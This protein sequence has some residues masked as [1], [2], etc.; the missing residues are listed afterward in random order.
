MKAILVLLFLIPFSG[1]SQNTLSVVVQKVNS[2][3]GRVSVAV[4]NESEGFLDF[5]KVYRSGSTRANMGTTTVT[6]DDLP[7]GIYAV[8]VFHDINDNDELDTNWM[9]IPKEDVGFS[10]AKMKLFG[11]PTFKECRFTINSDSEI[12]VSL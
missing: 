3:S 8:A 5:G 2:S 9:G 4:Y 6:V 12:Q 11:P 10:N 7:N 1:L